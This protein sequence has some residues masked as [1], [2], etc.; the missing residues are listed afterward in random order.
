MSERKTKF[1]SEQYLDC[2]T[3]LRTLIEF[4]PGDRAEVERMILDDPEIAGAVAALLKHALRVAATLAEECIDDEFARQAIE[5][6]LI[7]AG[8]YASNLTKTIV[9]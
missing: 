1:S 4:L 3:K 8:E 9:T 6:D 7:N 2:A 5:S